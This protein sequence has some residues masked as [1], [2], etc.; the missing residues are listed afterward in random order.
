MDKSNIYSLINTNLYFEYYIHWNIGKKY[1][2]IFSNKPIYF[3]CYEYLIFI[4][5]YSTSL[6]NI[7]TK[8]T[9]FKPATTDSNGLKCKFD[10]YTQHL[11]ETQELKCMKFESIVVFKL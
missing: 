2:E 10:I 11:F 7:L 9:V 8:E 5:F 3:E 4:D 1:F 6:Y